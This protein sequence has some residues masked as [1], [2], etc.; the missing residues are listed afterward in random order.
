MVGVT[1]QSKTPVPP[2]AKSGKLESQ[3]KLLTFEPGGM[4]C[5]AKW[6]SKW[7]QR[8]P[9]KNVGFQCKQVVRV[10]N[11]EKTEMKGMGCP[12]LPLISSLS[13][14][15]DEEGGW[16]SEII[17]FSISCL[18]VFE[19]EVNDRENRQDMGVT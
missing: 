19:I 11:I 1:F 6:A 14:W 17:S 3:A 18:S 10:K 15:L 7:K 8:A 5:N 2:E 4:N 16:T 12:S 9:Q 13:V